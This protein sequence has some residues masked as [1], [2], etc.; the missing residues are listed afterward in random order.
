MK[1]NKDRFEDLLREVARLI[2]EYEDPTGS[3]CSNSVV[4]SIEETDLQ[5]VFSFNGEK[6]VEVSNA[7]KDETL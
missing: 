7:E 3:N 4:C 1:T 2:R 6:F 5:K